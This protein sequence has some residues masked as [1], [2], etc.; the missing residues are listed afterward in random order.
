MIF[1]YILCTFVLVCLLPNQRRQHSSICLQNLESGN[2]FLT[3]S[4][5]LVVNADAYMPVLLYSSCS[6]L[7][8][9][10]HFKSSK[11]LLFL[12]FLIVVVL[13]PNLTVSLWSQITGLYFLMSPLCLLSWSFLFSADLNINIRSDG[14]WS[15][16]Y[17]SGCSE[18]IQHCL[19]SRF[20]FFK[21]TPKII[22]PLLMLQVSF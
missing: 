17:L 18:W 3:S 14:Q 12:F 5:T 7:Q 1:F 11:N 21:N 19:P 2:V 6:V 8:I 10:R 9:K 22:C 13:K 15:G 4:L 16:L 20:C